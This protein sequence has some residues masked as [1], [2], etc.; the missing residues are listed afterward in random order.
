M[1]GCLYVVA[2]PIGHLADL[3]R[4]AEDV[5]SGVAI[6]AAEDTRRTRGLL[7]AIGSGGNAG[8]PRLTSL[9]SHNESGRSVDLI[10]AMLGGDDVALVSDAG[11]PQVS[12]P[13]AEL[14]R[15]A[16]EAGLAVI[17]IP[18]ASAVTALLSVS[19]IPVTSY[20]FVG[21]PASKGA[22]RTRSF[23]AML[24]RR[25][26]VVWFEAPHR[27]ADAL[28]R[29]DTLAPDRALVVGRE[30]TKLHEEVLVGEPAPLLADLEAREAL[31][32]EF[33]LLLAPLPAAET[34][35]DDALADRILAELLTELPPAKAAR[36]AARLSG[37]DRKAL[38][39]R[40]LKRSP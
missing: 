12:D 10:D 22:E 27:V 23:E 25:E 37:V 8:G 31:R 32:G 28:T 33:A 2:T 18:G 39:Q 11:T 24:A 6:V 20:T 3:S 35:A 14:V 9:H 30:L 29:L 40:A 34:E 1:A 4:R 13:G 15:Q 21:F 16:F 17:P 7:S 38:Y 26:A 19:P 36:I 5:L